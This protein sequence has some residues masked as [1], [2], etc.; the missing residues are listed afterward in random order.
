LFIRTVGAS[1]Y[2]ASTL[3]PLGSNLYQANL[4]GGACLSEVNYY[5]TVQMTSGDTQS[6][7]SLAPTQF[8]ATPVAS[9][10]GDLAFETFEAATSSWT[11]GATGDT[12]TSGLWVLVDPVGTA[13]QPEDDFTASP[14]V[15]A[16]IT[17]QGAV[18]GGLG[19]ADVDGGV[20]TL[21]SPAFDCS[22]FDDAS[23]SYHRW[24]SNNAGAGAN[25]DSMPIEISGDNGVTWVQLENVTENAGAWVKKT[26]RIQTY[27]TASTQVR[28]RFRAQDLATGSIVE[29]GVDDVRVYG[30]SCTPALIGDLDGNGVVNGIDLGILLGAWGTN[31]YDLSGD[32]IISGP[33]LGLL[34][35][36][37]TV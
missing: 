8:Y 19:A 33:D 13:A 11:V 25:A 9:E 22:G 20:T 27:V 21:V 26:F 2:V 5:F 37:W 28:I 7:P 6:S 10:F 12:A 32:G 35:A 29:A 1:S 4:Q 23:I 31:T 30:A 14:G 15:K 17:G 16:W 24:Y 34:L 18:G 3:T 36:N